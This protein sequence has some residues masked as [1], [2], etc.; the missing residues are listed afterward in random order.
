MNQPCSDF[1]FKKI[2]VVDDAYI[3]RFLVEKLMKKYCFAE[4]VVSSESAVDALEQLSECA[5]TGSLPEVIFLDI[6][7]PE[8][9]GFEFLE[10][11]EKLPEIV[12]NTC[13]IIMLSSSLHPEDRE[14]AA[15]NPYVKTFMNKPLNLERLEEVG[16]WV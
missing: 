12:K 14:K 2:M 13:T 6:N 8:M 16:K 9:N 1:R 7:M 3:D 5:A 15:N 4:E 10:A 11:Y